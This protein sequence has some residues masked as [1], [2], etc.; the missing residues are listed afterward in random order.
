[1]ISSSSSY[2][3]GHVAAPETTSPSCKAEASKAIDLIDHVILKK[4]Q[5]N[6]L[7]QRRNGPI[8]PNECMMVVSQRMDAYSGKRENQ[9][10]NEG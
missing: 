1:M 2:E 6:N 7:Y 5:K 9:G 4:F 10:K 3:L 8:G